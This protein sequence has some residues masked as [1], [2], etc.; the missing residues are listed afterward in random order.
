MPGDS[1]TLANRIH[2]LGREVIEAPVRLVH[3]NS[4]GLAM[5]AVVLFGELSDRDALF[6]ML[7]RVP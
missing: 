7:D 2:L 4:E 1:H 6:V 3:G 5:A